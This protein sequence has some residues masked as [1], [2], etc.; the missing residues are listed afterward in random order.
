MPSSNISKLFYG[1]FSTGLKIRQMCTKGLTFASLTVWNNV[2]QT[3]SLVEC[4]LER[5]KTKDLRNFKSKS[6]WTINKSHNKK[7]SGVFLQILDDA[8][9]ERKNKLQSTGEEERVALYWRFFLGHILPLYEK[10]H[11]KH[12]SFTNVR[13]AN[14]FYPQGIR[15]TAIHKALEVHIFQKLTVSSFLP[16]S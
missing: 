2:R 13:T 15:Y 1:L 3:N 6:N 16:D 8:L 12:I 14:K 5:E 4:Q 7:V 9:L 10:V 11:S